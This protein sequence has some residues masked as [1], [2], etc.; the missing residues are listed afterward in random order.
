MK[1]VLS[2]GEEYKI[3]FYY[4]G[5]EYFSRRTYATITNKAGAVLGSG[6][7][8]TYHTDTF[9]HRT[10]RKMALARALKVSGLTKPVRTEIWKKL[11][12]QG[13]KK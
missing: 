7:V 10:G 11:F 13:L 4:E 3:S 5:A 12:E 2:N 1:V 9:N 8:G 6:Y